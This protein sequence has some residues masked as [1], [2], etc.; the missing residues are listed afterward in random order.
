[1]K[2]ILSAVA[3]L[4]FAM[5]TWAAAPPPVPVHDALDSLAIWVKPGEAQPFLLANRGGTYF[6]GST[7]EAAWDVGWMG[8]WVRRQRVSTAFRVTDAGGKTLL[9]EQAWCRVT[10]SDVTWY[11]PDTPRRELALFFRAADDDT[12]YYTATGGLRAEGNGVRAAPDSTRGALRDTLLSEVQRLRFTCADTSFAKAVAWAHLQLLFLLAENDSL[13]YAGIPWFNE[14]WGRDTFISLPGL[15]VTGHTEIAR[16]LLARYA[17]WVDR[18]PAS[19]TYGRVPNRVRPG[20][21]IAYNTADGTSWWLRG[22]FEYGLYVHDYDFWR[23]MV[24]AGPDTAPGAVHVAVAGVLAKTDSQGFLT[25]GDAET[26]MDAVGPAGAWSPRGSRAVEIE[27]LDDAALEAAIRMAAATQALPKDTLQRWRNA[28]ETLRRGFL[29]AYLA[30]TQ[31]RLWDHLNPD[32]TADSLLRPNQLFAL[33]VPLAPLIPPQ[34]ET[35]ITANVCRSLVTREG[36]RTLDP[37]AENFHPYHQDEHYPKDAAYHNGII[38]TW[39]SGP[40]KSALRKTGRADLAQ[41]MARYEADLILQRGLVGSL[42]E[43]T[44]ALPRPG[45]Q[46]RHSREPRRRRGASRNFCGPRIRTYWAY[47]PCRWRGGW[48]RSGY[49]IRAFQKSGDGWRRG[50]F[51]KARRCC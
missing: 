23:Q 26:W 7:G 46:S 44:D 19:A 37:A 12:L 39:L 32:G 14:G 33:T 24:A 38:W 48:S 50:C 40:A 47:A 45:R 30:P 10:P 13:L 36:V 15:L 2:H 51:L 18:S 31:D 42:P 4:L 35:K 41:Q 22:V 8:L 6:Y 3:L 34:L 27:A 25:H 16:K 17:G 43:V 20:E 49:S 29:A 5:L 1:M 28:R 9:L 11:W 21:E